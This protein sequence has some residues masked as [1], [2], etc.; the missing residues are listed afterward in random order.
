MPRPRIGITCEMDARPP[1]PRYELPLAYAEAVEQAGGIPVLLPLTPSVVSAKRL[2][3]PI[4]GV[5]FSGGN[6]LDPVRY[7]E[8]R[9][10]KTRRVPSEKELSDI[11]LLDAALRRGLPVLGICYGC[12]LINVARGG[13]LVQDIPSQC[14]GCL[15]HRPARRG[16]RLFHPVRLQ[17]GSLLRHILGRSRLPVNSSH[18]QAI[19]TIG[20][21]L[22]TV[23]WAPD[24]VIEG[25]EDPS[26]AFVLGVQWHPER[27]ADRGAHARLFRALVRAAR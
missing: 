13:S 6:D 22:R 20:R 7:G 10:P 26:H 3:S 8:S 25:V 4:G 16:E 11:R 12:Q 18:H 19:R 21:G 1:R 2:L 27:L 9:H 17:P 15:P 23:A 14:P 24:G 5:I